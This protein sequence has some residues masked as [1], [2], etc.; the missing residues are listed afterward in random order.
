MKSIPD[1]KPNEFLELERPEI[2]IFDGVVY[3]LLT[4]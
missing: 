2:F 1:T 4:S 3:L